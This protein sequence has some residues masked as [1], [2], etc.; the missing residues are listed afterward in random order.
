M[1]AGEKFDRKKLQQILAQVLQSIGPAAAT[2]EYR[3]V[4][5]AAS[6]LH[7]VDIVAGDI[8]FLLRQRAGVDAFAAALAE[9]SCVKAPELLED[10]GQYMAI[11]SVDGVDVE[12]STVEWE[13]DGDTAECMGAG[14][15]THFVALPCGPHQIPTVALE[16]R[17][18]TEWSRGRADRSGPIA[19]F[20]RGKPYDEALLRRGLGDEAERRLKELE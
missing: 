13:V 6:L 20:M 9:F 11:F 17:L 18:L 19:A 3:L 10:D 16:L 1:G 14:P 7:G 5:T 8:D 2:H 4:G 12:L 15:W